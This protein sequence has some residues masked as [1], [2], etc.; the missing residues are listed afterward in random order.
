[1]TTAVTLANTAAGLVVAKF[2]AATVT[3]SE[4]DAALASRAG[5]QRGVVSA[6]EL[7][8][9]RELARRRGETIVMTN[10][11]F[12]VLHEGH[13]RYLAAAK[14]LG[15]RLIVAVND[16]ASVAALKGPTRPLNT[17]ASRMCV[18]AAL[19]V[20]DW[21]VPFSAATPRD[22]I[23]QILPDV[24]VKGGDYAVSAIA[25]ASEVLAAGGRVQSVDF[26]PGFSTTNL[27]ERIREPMSK[28]A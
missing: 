16:D 28:D 27:V 12:D 21:V 15:T 2:G 5:V 17:L 24:L 3:R 14:A 13:V 7:L 11:C 4:L 25:G 22:L 6:A 19:D 26:Y 8:R 18:L 23:A 1:M 10:G 9:Q 20:V